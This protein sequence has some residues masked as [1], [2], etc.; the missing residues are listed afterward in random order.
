VTVISFSLFLI[1][2]QE[3]VQMNSLKASA[4]QWPHFGF[5][6][7]RAALIEGGAQAALCPL[8]WIQ[9]HWR[10]IVWKFAALLRA[11]PFK[12]AADNLSP[13]WLLSQL[14]YRYEREINAAQRS[15]LKR[16]LE[17]DD[18]ASRYLCLAVAQIDRARGCVELTDG[19]YSCW[20][21]AFDAPLRELLT[22]DRLFEGQK[23]EI[24]GAQL[25]GD[26]GV[27]ALE[28]SRPDCPAK[29][30]L[31]R[32]CIRRTRWDTKLGFQFHAPAFLKEL[33]HVHAQG[34][35]LPAIKLCI[36]RCYPL[37][38]RDD[39]K[40]SVKSE[41]EHFEFLERRIPKA[42]EESPAF[43]PIQK[44]RACQPGRPDLQCVITFW[45]AIESMPVEGSVATFTALKTP[46]KAK[47]LSWL[48]EE[49]ATSSVLL[50]S[51]TKTSRIMICDPSAAAAPIKPTRLHEIFRKGDFDLNG[52]FLGKN[53]SLLWFCPVDS[54]SSEAE[55]ALFCVR[56]PQL[57]THLSFS[58]GDAIWWRDTHFL[59]HD[60][61]AGV[62]M[63]EFTERT[64]FKKDPRLRAVEI[65]KYFIQKYQELIK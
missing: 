30:S 35:Y 65:S 39:S 45:C 9:N 21:V 44:I 53:S 15:A 50:L 8:D 64:D 18:S 22:R 55:K 43:S 12:Y 37:A 58:A 56:L 36:L 7:A 17:R 60:A 10:W 11:F 38:F 48:A 32:N 41:R 26:D 27:P 25:T 40:G 47:R 59:N 23:V 3:I 13:G 34:G 1:R 19:W 29:L 2:S 5:E 20:T 57:L 16:C 33:S 4:F 31:S 49:A 6:E 63:F 54:D 62:Y 14:A 51:A 61:K 24:C 28:G 46:L 42:D 52:Y